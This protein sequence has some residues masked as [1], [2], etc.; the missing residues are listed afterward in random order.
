METQEIEFVIEGK[1]IFISIQEI[2]GK[3]YKQR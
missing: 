3:D 2:G 1:L